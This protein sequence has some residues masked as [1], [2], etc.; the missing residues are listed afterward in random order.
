MLSL[1]MPKYAKVGE[2]C[3]GSVR[4]NMTSLGMPRYGKFR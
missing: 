4:Q 1:G 2:S 3:S